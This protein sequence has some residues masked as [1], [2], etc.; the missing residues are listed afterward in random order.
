MKQITKRQVLMLHS[1][2]VSESGGLDGLRDEGLL[3]SAINAPFQ[4]FDD[5]D[6]YPTILEKAARLCYNLVKN[7]PFI[8]GNKRI[9]THCMIVFLELNNTF[10]KYDDKELIDIILSIADGK[11]DDKALVT[12]LQ[13][14]I[15]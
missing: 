9:G 1:M 13:A 4:S 14:H 2:L 11:V 10:I 6:F 3:E 5:K 12:W 15:S 8:D 7:H